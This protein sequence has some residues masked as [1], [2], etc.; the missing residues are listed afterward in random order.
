[1]SLLYK[2]LVLLPLHCRCCCHPLLLF[3]AHMH[4]SARS[5]KGWGNAATSN[6]SKAEHT[7][8]SRGCCVQAVVQDFVGRERDSRDVRYQDR[9]CWKECMYDMIRDMIADAEPRS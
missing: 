7:P 3:A 4:A 6:T 9:Y 8:C 5:Y 2:I 1:M